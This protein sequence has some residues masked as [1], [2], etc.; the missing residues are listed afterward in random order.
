[1]AVAAQF[2]LT[3]SGVTTLRE[4]TEKTSESDL[5]EIDGTNQ[6]HIKYVQITLLGTNISHQKSLFEDDFPFPLVGSVNSLEGKSFPYLQKIFQ[7]IYLLKKSQPNPPKK[8]IPILK[9]VSFPPQIQHQKTG[10]LLDMSPDIRIQE[11]RK[12]LKFGRFF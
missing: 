1:M 12:G 4:Q 11:V 8:R 3:S 7:N 2:F 5:A 9:K 6:I 10:R